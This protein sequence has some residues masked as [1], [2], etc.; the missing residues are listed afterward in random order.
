MRAAAPTIVAWTKIFDRA[1]HRRDEHD[2]AFDDLRLEQFGGTAWSST[3]H[4]PNFAGLFKSSTIG[5]S[6]CAP[7]V[8]SEVG[9]AA[10]SLI[11]LFIM[12]GAPGASE[13]TL[14]GLQ[15]ISC[16]FARNSAV[17][18]F[19]TGTVSQNYVGPRYDSLLP[20]DAD[21]EAETDAL[22]SISQAR[23]DG[24]D[25]LSTGL[26]ATTMGAGG[27]PLSNV[28]LIIA[29]TL[30]YQAMCFMADFCGYPM[31]RIIDFDGFKMADANEKGIVPRRKFNL[32]PGAGRE[33]W[34]ARNPSLLGV[35][36][37]FDAFGVLP[38]DSSTKGAQQRR[39]RVPV[40]FMLSLNKGYSDLGLGLQIAFC[41]TTSG[42]IYSNTHYAESLMAWPKEM[43]AQLGLAAGV[44]LH[45]ASA[46][47]EGDVKERLDRLSY[48]PAAV[49][50][51]QSAPDTRPRF[52]C[53]RCSYGSFPSSAKEPKCH[54]C[55][56]RNSVVPCDQ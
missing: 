12:D 8:V 51:R 52:R 36:D 11:T 45:V 37:A 46:V 3:V 24:V 17:G 44:T 56:N 41:S 22:N 5:Y 48:V 10:Y 50:A 14:A 13:A 34:V 4:A 23:R 9:A 27:T 35:F 54:G 53:L 6:Y 7:F 26:L 28:K 49:A 19:G 20:T 55:L 39:M 33:H 25:L 1:H 16:Y 21:A 29:P 40:N 32:Q 42:E 31:P 18:R 30:D 43:L 15:R 2:V 47:E 38:P